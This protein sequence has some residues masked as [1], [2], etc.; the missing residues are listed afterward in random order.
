MKLI[1]LP[2]CS[3]SWIV[4]YRYWDTLEISVKHSKTVKYS[5]EIYNKLYLLA[6]YKFLIY[7][8]IKTILEKERKNGLKGNWIVL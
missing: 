3:P 6:F 8:K 2:L 5:V 1:K 4:H 7:Q